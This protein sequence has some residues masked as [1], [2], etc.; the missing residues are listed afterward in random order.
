MGTSERPAFSLIEFR[1][2]P[3][4]NARAVDLGMLVE[5]TT[6][7]A[8]VV[9]LGMRAVV[10]EA[11]LSGLDAL[12]RELVVNR[13]AVIEKEILGAIQSATEPGDVLKILATRNTYSMH[14]TAPIPFELP[15]ARTRDHTLDETVSH[16]ILTLYKRAIAAAKVADGVRAADLMAPRRR[17]STLLRLGRAAEPLA[18]LALPIDM[19]PPWIMPRTFIRP[20]AEHQH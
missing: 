1:P 16:Y 17:V 3:S 19:P 12:S 13:S 5:W 18:D 15:R 14:I 8:W 7:E 9:G 4:T 20:L 2:D 6:D 10:D 11:K